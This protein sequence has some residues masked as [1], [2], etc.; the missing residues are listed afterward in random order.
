MEEKGL[1]TFETFEEFPNKFLIVDKNTNCYYIKTKKEDFVAT[2][3]IDSATIEKV[4]GIDRIVILESYNNII[5]GS[6]ILNNKRIYSLDKKL[7]SDI[8]FEITPLSRILN[9]KSNNKY[10]LSLDDVYELINFKE[11]DPKTYKKTYRKFYF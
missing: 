11:E 5:D 8:E 2:R 1:K 7:V 6:F 4:D 9:I 3:K 10:Y